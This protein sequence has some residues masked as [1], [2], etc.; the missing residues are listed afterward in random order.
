MSQ[1]DCEFYV[2]ISE[3][4]QFRYER[5]TFPAPRGDNNLRTAHSPLVGDLVHLWGD[6]EETRGTFRV[7]ER[8]WLHSSYGSKNWP[9]GAEAL[10][11]P[12]L[13]VIVEPAVG[14]FVDE[15]TEG[16]SQA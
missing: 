10:V 11:P 14:P 4:Q 9:F 3:A 12:I 1:V 8:S 13:T 6:T 2:R 7:V 5:V 15:A 16:R